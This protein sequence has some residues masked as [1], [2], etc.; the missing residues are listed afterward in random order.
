MPKIML[1]GGEPGEVLLITGA[2]VVS[3]LTTTRDPTY[4][5]L[6]L[7]ISAGNQTYRASAHDPSTGALSSI[8]NGET[9]WF[10]MYFGSNQAPTNG[11]VF[12]LVRDSSNL[13]WF[14]MVGAATSGQQIAQFNSGT[15]ASPVWTNVGSAF[16]FSNGYADVD[17][18][19]DINTSGGHS[20]EFM[21]AGTLVASGTFSQSSFTNIRSYDIAAIG[22][23]ATGHF[24]Q[25][26]ITE[27]ISTLG[28]VVASCPPTALGANTGWTGPVTGINETGL[29]DSNFIYSDT[30]SQVST[31]VTTDA[32]VPSG[33]AIQ[34]VVVNARVKSD[35]ATGPQDIQAA[36][37]ISGT[38]YFSPTLTVG[39]GFD[40]VPYVFPVSPATLATWSEA[41]FN[42]SETGL[43]S[44]A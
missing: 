15:G 3:T 24:S 19:I 26:L 4:S 35:N 10:H 41:V 25:V 37:R 2:M 28:A 44:I 23:V 31:F 8:V 13:P 9:A 1:A 34:A 17:L 20:F 42:G 27:G 29:I 38:D 30:A 32:V 14:R 39:G 11:V 36:V 21:R 18:R 22:S 5:R 43:R 7:E 12:I 6:S 33:N 40:F 16:S